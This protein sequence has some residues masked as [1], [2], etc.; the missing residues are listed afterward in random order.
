MCIIINICIKVEGTEYMI[1]IE[2]TLNLI[3]NSPC[4]VGSIKDLGSPIKFGHYPMGD[5]SI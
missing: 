2:Q 4:P 1:Y 3:I 5:I